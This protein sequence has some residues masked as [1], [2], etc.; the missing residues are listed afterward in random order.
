M[1]KKETDIVELELKRNKPL[2]PITGW[3]INTVEK[4]EDR[5]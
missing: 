3:D 5:T 1:I 4:T 2:N